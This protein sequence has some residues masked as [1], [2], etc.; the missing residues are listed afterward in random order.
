METEKQIPRSPASMLPIS[1]EIP[2]VPKSS[3]MTQAEKD[4][5]FRERNLATFKRPDP[6]DVPDDEEL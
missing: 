3:G 1:V 2:Y 4:R 6:L 5:L